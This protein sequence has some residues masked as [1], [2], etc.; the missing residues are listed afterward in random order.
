MAASLSALTLVS[1]LQRWDAGAQRL[2]VNL[3]VVPVGDPR[4]P[5]T[6]GWSTVPAGPAFEGATP[7]VAVHIGS[8]PTLLPTVA[9]IAAKGAPFRL[10]PPADQAA[11]FAALAA[12]YKLTAAPTAPERSGAGNLRKYLPIS[13]RTAFGF[14]APSTDLAVVDDSYH[15]ARRCKPETNPSEVPWS[16][17][18]SWGDI[19]AMLLRQ[20][21]VAQAAG[22][23]HQIELDVGTRFAA[24][25]WLFFSLAGG[26]FQP[27]A[28]ADPAFVRLFGTRV[29]ALGGARPVFTPVL[30]PIAADAATAIAL[31]P[32]DAVFPEA[33]EFDD[34]FAKIV[35][36][37]QARTADHAEDGDTTFLAPL[38]DMGI[39]LGWDD[40]SMVV[41]LDR[42][43]SE[44]SP[45][46]S[47][48]PLAPTGA[49]GYR[50]DVR[51]V[52]SP[53]WT[54]LTRIQAA[55]L[56]IGAARID[57]FET[58]LMVEVHPS[59]LGGTQ[60][61]IPPHYTFW[62][63]GSLVADT[64][65]Q[66]DIE[67]EDTS[68]PSLYQPLGNGAAPLRYGR[69]YEFRVRMVDAT[70]GGPLLADVIHNPA[71]APTARLRF[72]R[73]VPLGALAVTTNGASM[74][75]QFL[76]QRPGI[77]YPQAEFSGA[78][79]AAQRLAA[80]ARASRAAGTV[81]ALL[82]PDPDAEF[83]EL[84]VMVLMPRFD[85]TGQTAG[86]AEL[87][88]TTRAFPALDTAGEAGAGLQIELAWVDCAHLTDVTWAS[89]SSTLG[90]E[91]G[92]V[93]LPTGRM[94]RIEARAV[95]RDDAGY[96][97]NEHARYGDRVLLTKEP[98]FQ[99][100]SVEPALFA[101]TLPSQALASVFLQPDHVTTNPSQAAVVQASAAPVLVVRIAQAVDLVEDDGV[102][103]AAAGQRM[104]FGCRGLK[105][106]IAPDYSSIQ[107]TA[108][109]EM[110]NR[111]INVLRLPIARD[112]SWL[113]YANDPFKVTRTVTLVGNGETIVTDLGVFGVQH[114][115]SLQAR[116]G[117]VD[118]EQFELCVI[119]ALEPPL[120]SD[121][122]PYELD[123]RYD[124]VAV[125]L[126]GA[127]QTF[128]VTNR[129]PIT[130][131]PRQ[132]P[133]IVATGHAF[134][135]YRVLGDYEETG[136]RE[137]VLWVE[138]A[139]PPADPRDR[140]FA[141]VLYSTADPMLLPATEPLADPPSYDKR[142]LDPELVRVVRPGQSRDLAGLGA[143]QRLVP[144]ETAFGEK[145][146]HYLLR[147]PPT[148]SA[149][150]PELFGFFTYEFAVG[151]DRGPA[152]DP[153]WVTAQGRFGPALVLEGV[154]HPAPPLP[155]DVARD[156]VADML[157][158]SSEF[159]RA[160]KD[161][162]VLSPARP[163]TEVWAVAY[164][165][166]RQADGASWRNVQIDRRRATIKQRELGDRQRSAA[167]TAI[168]SWRGAEIRQGLADWGLSEKTPIGFLA[169]ELLPEPNARFAD[170]L[171][172]DLG[173][174]RVLRSSRL[175]SAGDTCCL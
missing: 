124:V 18:I 156:R 113:G 166:V 88:R 165:R 6:Q 78:V 54:S 20:P 48:L 135:D 95:A 152:T 53:N 23:I 97:G 129:L 154:Q 117:T 128:S 112:W 109:A 62:R 9:D 56:A 90:A 98:L 60:F 58:E 33:V 3:L 52:G 14:T 172:G 75:T 136:T 150:S 81:T 163:N 140:Y 169:V 126:T 114:T 66:R 45:D 102:L 101:A 59:Q 21:K 168:A 34:G 12:Q 83:V 84:R 159:A 145:P 138:F 63:G 160:V 64:D 46:G 68:R 31:G 116:R 99:Q 173:Q 132:V 61:W 30:F 121:G 65:D 13:Y 122:L 67:A 94:V 5:L 15:C 148:L 85:P 27:Q 32:L 131:T 36:A 100:A 146:R 87:Y 73:Y 151:H 86:Y 39:R 174:V 19:I 93:S 74:P 44:T 96:F 40:E 120:G 110:P 51:S 16:D 82:V 125:L 42:G 8:D 35:H 108:L 80:Q 2:T 11:I 104:L 111:W 115:I 47:A 77:G 55:G 118:R 162:R 57:P 69:D 10:E 137:R 107:L 143:M 149:G 103:M 91:T 106:V 49:A 1:Y 72:R 25:G 167:V 4:Q 164:A 50:V 123:V 171:G 134:S 71:P 105:H 153:I 24:G 158:V 130:Q 133:Q 147:P 7:E 70:G 43:L 89:G 38:R 22:L 170:P 79:N 29:P 142:P 28:A 41:R 76:L 37:S 139:E 127:P 92:P 17:E 141:R 161:G 175:V 144:C 119:D 157:H 26:A 155:I